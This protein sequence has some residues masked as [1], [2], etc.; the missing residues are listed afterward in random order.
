MRRSKKIYVIYFDTYEGLG[1]K[2]DYI[3]YA[4]REEAEIKIMEYKRIDRICG[5]NNEYSVVEISK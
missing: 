3:E 4:T 5:N 2:V 1:E